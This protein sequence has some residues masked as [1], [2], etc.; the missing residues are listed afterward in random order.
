MIA[1]PLTALKK[2]PKKLAWTHMAEEA[3][4]R[5]KRSFTTAPV[6][7]QPDPMKPFLEEVDTS[8]IGACAILP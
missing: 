4:A 5:L 2:A 7:K 3:F 8:E 6:L 1:A